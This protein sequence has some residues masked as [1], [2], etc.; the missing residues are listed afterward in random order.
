MHRIV[1]TIYLYCIIHTIYTIY[2]IIHWNCRDLRANFNDFRLLCEKYNPIIYCLQ[3]TMLAKDA[4]VIRGFNCINLTS[5]DIGGITCGGVSVLARD[6]FPY[7]KCTINTILQA[8]LK[9]FTVCS[10]CLPPSKS[11]NIVL[12]T[13]L[14]DQLPTPFI[15]CGDFN[16]HSMNWG[17]EKTIVGEMVLIS[18]Y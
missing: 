7:S 10:L 2:N 11:L 13:P 6:G 4:F 1:F 5:H 14:I 8:K 17:C 16:G 3:E 15:V 18:F 9:L 12:L